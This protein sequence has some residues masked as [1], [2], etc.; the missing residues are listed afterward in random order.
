MRTFF[1][2]LLLLLA[3]GFYVGQLQLR[4]S[5][6]QVR[7]AE[8]EAESGLALADIHKIPLPDLTDRKAIAYS[9]LQCLNASEC[10]KIPVPVALETDKKP[11][12]GILVVSDVESAPIVSSALANGMQGLVTKLLNSTRKKLA[13]KK[14]KLVRFDMIA[15]AALL[16]KAP[17]PRIQSLPGLLG[18]TPTGTTEY[19]V[20]PDQLLIDG[21]VDRTG[22]LKLPALE[23]FWTENYGSSPDIKRIFA[24]DKNTAF[25][26]LS[27]FADGE[28]VEP[29]YRGHQ[30]FENFTIA[31][32]DN[33]AILGAEY[34]TRMVNQDGSFVY[35]YFPETD[36]ASN[37]YN[38][39]RH[40]GTTYSMV[41]V[42][43]KHK[44]EKLLDA[45]HRAFTYLI[46]QTEECTYKSIKGRCVVEKDNV[47]VGGNGLSILAMTEYQK[48]TGDD[49]YLSVA[50]ELATWIASTQIEDGRFGVH[51][52][53]V[54]TGVPSDF[55]SGYYPGE[56]IFA[57]TRLYQID[58]N[59][60][61]LDVADKNA[62]YLI[63]IRDKGVEIN[64]LNHDHW[65]LYGLNEL[66]RSRPREIFLEHQRKIVTAISNAQML[67]VPVP[68]WKGAYN[69][70]PRS[71]P[72]ATRSE[73]LTAAY[74]LEKDFG[75]QENTE[76]ILR[77]IR[78]GIK[79]QLRT[80]I[81]PERAIFL[82]NPQRSLGG[83]TGT[84]TDYSVR[85]DDVQHNISAIV[86]TADILRDIE[87]KAQS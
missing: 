81:R 34:L 66:H 13:G 37:D 5:S 59:K 20:T 55:V 63:T 28:V 65:L 33:A 9:F 84:L 6:N 57:L 3:L 44:D 43:E 72:A 71:T 8:S 87:N 85:I 26:V 10:T 39:L 31:D 25:S 12:G 54:R 15:A 60:K 76:K 24:E 53:N 79:F 62:T 46:N 48:V 40:A 4:D 80:L 70:P 78:E 17:V 74:M 51:K 52:L 73:G 29:L 58:K 67:N 11:R 2:G 32:L 82:K 69:R 42:Y 16:D 22:A 38:I 14:S 49:R 83:F 23:K 47:K 45:I 21:L 68:D 61:W 27:V 50:Q 35:E 86:R 75:S 77:T 64:K 19:L 18:Y 56:A 36:T 7:P 1:L 41:Q 30:Y